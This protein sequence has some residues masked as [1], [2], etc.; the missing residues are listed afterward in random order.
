MYK[1][2]RKEADQCKTFV[3]PDVF[4]ETMKVLDKI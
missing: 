3:H 2:V 1:K 4:M